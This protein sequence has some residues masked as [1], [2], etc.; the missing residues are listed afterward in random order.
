MKHLSINNFLMDKFIIS[1]V[2]NCIADLSV[3]S[4][5][6]DLMMILLSVNLHPEWPPMFT[7]G[8]N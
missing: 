7:E 5:E 8:K 6:C 4:R 1:R 2:S 3:S